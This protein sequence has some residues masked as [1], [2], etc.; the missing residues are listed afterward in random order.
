MNLNTLDKDILHNLAIWL[1]VPES[2]LRELSDILPERENAYF[3]NILDSNTIDFKEALVR[4]F[5]H[6]L[7]KYLKEKNRYGILNSI[8]RMRQL[9]RKELI[10][11][12]DCRFMQLDKEL[13]TRLALPTIDWNGHKGA[14]CLSHDIDS[15]QDYQYIPEVY[16]L[17]KKYNLVSGFNFLTNWGYCID[18]T[19]LSELND[20]GFEIGLH[21][22]THDI[23]VGFR[24]QERIKRELSLAFQSLGFPVEGYR[25]PAFAV[26]KRLLAV[27]RELGIKYDSSMKTISCYS[28]QSAEVFYPYRYPGVGIWEVPLTIQD[29]RVFRD[30]HLSNEEALG[31]IKE[32]TARIVN[33]GGVC[34]INNHPVL[35][36]RRRY[37][38]EQLLEWLSG[39]KEAWVTRI[40]L[41]VGFM[42]ERERRVLD[43]NRG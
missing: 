22:Y 4:R 38:Y 24:S 29:D 30:L 33:M 28:P 23:A 37:Y 5:T 18:K 35:I 25:A 20:N 36:Q 2:R 16:R 1:G 14:V 39:F 26:S 8:K 11:I 40:D 27:L 17:N 7:V 34:V 31:V 21:G 13:R 32:L 41:L 19:L 10:E 12:S 6:K 43:E 42:E 15:R 3:E 9:F